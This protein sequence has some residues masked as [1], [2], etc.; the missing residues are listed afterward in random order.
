MRG[1]G[2]AAMLVNHANS[3]AGF[4]FECH[5]PRRERVLGLARSTECAIFMPRVD[6]DA[7]GLGESQVVDRARTLAPIEALCAALFRGRSNFPERTSVGHPGDAIAL[8]TKALPRR[9]LV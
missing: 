5:A 2:S 3:V 4:P 8:S 9:Q 6:A 1:D 7:R